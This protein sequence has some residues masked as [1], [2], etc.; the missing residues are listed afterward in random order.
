[1][2][3]EVF[4]TNV[5]TKKNADQVIHLIKRLQP[6]KINFDLEDCDRILRIEAN[7]IQVQPIV[8]LV[9]DL[10]FDCIPLD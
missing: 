10:G 2:P 7:E 5:K 4:R 3:V 8:K 6:G 9:V 1:M